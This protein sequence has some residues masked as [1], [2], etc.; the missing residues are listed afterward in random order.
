M[1][2]DPGASQHNCSAT[3]RMV[4]LGCVACRCSALDPVHT[5]AQASLR[6]V[7][8]LQRPAELRAGLERQGSS[9]QHMRCL[10]ALAKDLADPR[11]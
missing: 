2:C 9:L 10:C 7:L 4:D 3:R 11:G 5:L 1:P 6:Q 8:E